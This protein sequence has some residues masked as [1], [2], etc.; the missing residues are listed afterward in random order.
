MRPWCPRCGTDTVRRVHRQGVLELLS[1]LVRVLSFRCQL[2]T[3]RFRALTFASFPFHSHVDRREYVRLATEVKAAIV[4]DP[5][6]VLDMV[7]D[8]SMG[9]CTLKTSAPLSTGARLHLQLQPSQKEPVITVETAM[10][11]WVR[12]Y[13]V[14]LQFLEFKPDD[15]LRLSLFVRG[16][17]VPAMAGN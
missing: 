5:P 14:G 2:C 13:T 9:G 4:G 1:A 8:L 3:H 11:R 12:D 6:R 16:L 17:L 10:V 15:K 7:T